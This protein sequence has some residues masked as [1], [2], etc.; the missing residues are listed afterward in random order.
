MQSGS[1]IFCK[2]TNKTL[3][4]F[5][6]ALCKALILKAGAFCGEVVPSRVYPC[7]RVRAI[8]EG[9]VPT[10]NGELWPGCVQSYS[11]PLSNRHGR[12]GNGRHMEL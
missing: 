9:W 7:F 3:L 4:K 10:A 5:V 1:H 8:F 2:E 6:E 12:T 11:F